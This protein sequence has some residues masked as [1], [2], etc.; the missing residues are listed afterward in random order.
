MARIRTI[1]PDF[2]T[3]DRVG[4]CSVSARLLFVATWNFADDHGGL[5][6]SAK[7]LKAQAFPYD[8]IDC[9]PLV[10]ELLQ[11]RLLIEYEVDGKKYLHIKG[12]RTH[13][14]VEKPAKPRVPLYDESLNTPRLLPDS[15]PTSGG[16]SPGSSGLFSGREGKGKEGTSPEGRDTR[17]TRSPTDPAGEARQKRGSRIPTPFLLTATMREWAKSETP[18]VDVEFETKEFADYWRTVP[19]QKG[20]KLDWVLT[21]QVRL[22]EIQ[23]RSKPHRLNGR[24]EPPKLTWRPEEEPDHAPG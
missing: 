21:W 17:A 3:D 24:E 5:D 1:K 18:D 6:R 16:N 23:R 15:S 2:W 8:N 19:G 13:Q 11:A 7:Q 12:F 9:E 4:E 14:K 22:R 10:Q 20:C